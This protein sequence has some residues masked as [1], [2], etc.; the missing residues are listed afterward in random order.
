MAVEVTIRHLGRLTQAAVQGGDAQFK[1]LRNALL[2]NNFLIT[3]ENE[4]RLEARRRAY[5]T[6][7]DWP[8][9]VSVQRNGRQFAIRYFLFIPWSWIIALV[10]LSL[11]ILP[12]A[13]IP[14]AELALALAA[15][16]AGL[17]IYKQ[18]FDCRPDARYW[19]RQPRQRWN[20]IMEQ[21]IREAFVSR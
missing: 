15:V 4:T 3:T 7:D 19:Q 17:A 10:F 16:V 1:K 13:G 2:I 5:L 8:M 6:Q 11:L 21:L 9:R 12:F 14:R 18:K 20:Q